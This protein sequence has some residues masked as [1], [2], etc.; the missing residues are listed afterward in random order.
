VN[1]RLPDLGCSRRSRYS[2]SASTN[3][4]V[5]LG[6]GRRLSR[7]RL[8]RAMR[9]GGRRSPTGTPDRFCGLAG[10]SSI[11]DTDKSFRKLERLTLDCDIL[12]R[13]GYTSQDTTPRAGEVAG[14]G[15][16][17]KEA[18]VDEKSCKFCGAEIT[19]YFPPSARKLGRGKY[20][21]VSCAIE[22]RTQDRDR[23]RAL[24]VPLTCRGWAFIPI[25][26]G[27]YAIVDKSDWPTVRNIVWQPWRTKWT[28]YARAARATLPN[29]RR[30]VSMH[31]LVAG[32]STGGPHVDHI[33][34]NGLDNRRANLRLATHSQNMSNRFAPPTS[35]AGYYGVTV[36]NVQPTR[37]N[38]VIR[39]DGK[40]I[41]LG[42]FPDPETAARAYDRAALKLRGPITALNFPSE[43]QSRQRGCP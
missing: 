38:A 31:R 21:S 15:A 26:G 8:I 36:T 39:H 2:T 19:R 41:Y 29:Q 42:R 22:A 14:G 16:S 6:C 43:V 9:S 27:Q 40:T 20:C 33:N 13:L 7:N 4:A 12:A 32:V 3:T 25:K 5:M 23:E 30:C 11:V 18:E 34:G 37:F 35:A 10:M 28:T 17:R 24:L 1:Q